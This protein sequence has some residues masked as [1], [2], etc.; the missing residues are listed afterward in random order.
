[1][2]PEAKVSFFDIGK[3]GEDYLSLSPSYRGIYDAAR[4]AG[5]NVHSNSWGSSCSSPPCDLEY[6]DSC[7]DA[8]SFTWDNPEYLIL[9]AASNEGDYGKRSVGSPAVAKNSISVGATLVRYGDDDEV[10][11]QST[12]TSFS[13]IGP[14]AD[15]RYGVDIAAPG[16]YI[17]SAYSSSPDVQEALID[18]GSGDMQERAAHF[19]SGTSMA[20]PI[21]SGNAILVRQFF[22]DSTFWAEV[23]N[24]NDEQ[25]GG[26]ITNPT[27]A[28]V[29][30]ILLHSGKN[31]YRYATPSDNSA[32]RS[33]LLGEAPDIFQGYG[34]ITLT[35]V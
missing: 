7:E 6:D 5:A 35:N 12:M 29:K 13:S 28:L 19:M 1:M 14:T 26:A 23:C 2:A 4:F 34:E 10:I 25:C 21:A 22:M 3:V 27:A 18:A 16:D 30:A 15:N 8:D 9:F 17:M 32:V 24:V 11:S 31:V 33:Q 20:T